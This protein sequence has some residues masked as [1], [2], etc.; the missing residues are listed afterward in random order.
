MPS[1]QAC[2]AAGASDEPRAER[3]ERLM[4]RIAAHDAEAL[5][6]V[7]AQKELGLDTRQVK[8]I[9]AARRTLAALMGSGLLP[10][11]ASL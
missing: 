4:Q 7:E 9:R 1:D 11:G 8:A 3:I 10:E 5:A 2:P 6:I